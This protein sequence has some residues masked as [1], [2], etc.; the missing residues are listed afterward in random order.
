M[1]EYSDPNTRDVARLERNDLR[2][3]CSFDV[4]LCV[5]NFE[6]KVSKSKHVDEGIQGLN[7]SLRT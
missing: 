4:L 1:F 3:Q 7:L 5:L 2:E 6:G